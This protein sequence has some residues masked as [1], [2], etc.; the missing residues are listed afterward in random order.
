MLS[1]R[2]TA[3]LDQGSGLEAAAKNC[4]HAERQ[5]NDGYTSIRRCPHTSCLPVLST[6]GS[7][8]Y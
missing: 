8:G 3:M 6:P 4:T 2:P 5:K 1:A 7:T